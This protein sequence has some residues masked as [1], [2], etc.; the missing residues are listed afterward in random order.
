MSHHTT[1]HLSNLSTRTSRRLSKAHVQGMSAVEYRPTKS[2]YHEP[3]AATDCRCARHTLSVLFVDNF[4]G[5]CKNTCVPC[6]LKNQSCHLM[7]HVVRTFV[8]T[9]GST[10]F[11]RILT[12]GAREEMMRQASGKGRLSYRCTRS[13]RQRKYRK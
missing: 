3:E 2:I 10:D 11:Y 4:G 5:R 12:V 13:L 6:H 9:R 7:T 8:G 1:H